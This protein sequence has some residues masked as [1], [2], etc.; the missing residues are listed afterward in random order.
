MAV[1]FTANVEVS[2]GVRPPL[3]ME[4]NST[5]LNIAKVSGSQ[6]MRDMFAVGM[7]SETTLYAPRVSMKK[8][9]INIK[10]RLQRM[11]PT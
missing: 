8:Q 6:C 1:V 10:S 4:S 3:V 2:A 9:D 11:F 7:L 5:R